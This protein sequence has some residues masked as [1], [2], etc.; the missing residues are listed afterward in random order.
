MPDKPKNEFPKVPPF[1]TPG[2]SEQ[3]VE[4]PKKQSANMVQPPP[5]GN[6]KNSSQ[7]GI[8]STLVS[9]ISVIIM[10]IA[11]ISGAWFAY[12]VLKSKP[13]EGNVI[14]QA[15]QFQN[16]EPSAAEQ[17]GVLSKVIVVG[18]A[19]IIGWIFSAFG[20]RVLG[21]NW[22]P[23]ALQIYTWVVLGGIILL[24]IL[25]ISRL[26]QQEYHFSNYVRY[27]FLFGA[28]MFALIGLHIILERHSL[29]P[30]GV[31]ILLTS[32]G[33]FILIVYHYIFETNVV[34]GMVW[35]DLIFFFVTTTVSLLMLAHFGMLNRLRNFMDRTFN[36]IDNP[37]VPPE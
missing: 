31:F 15:E 36:P 4:E 37:F 35:G 33:H 14:P 2:A 12:G 29:I 9:L 19:Y 21:N 18:L 1:V 13:D 26:Y 24:Q 16:N 8:F 11:L 32:L 27:L 28:G 22:L 10:G 6:D 7:I 34:P 3:Y 17:D 25:I 30:F 5:V 23:Y 20:V